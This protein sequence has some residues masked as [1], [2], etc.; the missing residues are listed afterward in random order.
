[1]KKILLLLLI[2]PLVPILQAKPKIVSL[3][4]AVTEIICFLDGES[5]LTGRSSACD[6]PAHI[7]KLPAV[8]DHTG[9]YLEKL[10]AMKPDYVIANNF[11]VK[12]KRLKKHVRTNF[13]EV[14]IK[15][16]EDYIK[17]LK[18]IGQILNCP[19]KGN[20]EAE[21][22]FL[23]LQELRKKAAQQTRKPTA[24]WII[25]HNPLMIAGPGSLPD[26]V[27]NLAGLKNAAANVKDEYFK[28]SRE[29]LALQKPDYIIWTVNGVPFR[30]KGF[31]AKYR[32]DQVISGLNHDILL[33]PGPRIFDGIN[34]L[35]D[36]L[37]K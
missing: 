9:F 8:G 37:K 31:W 7:K 4:P 34:Q 33:R 17:A 5:M 29:W 27:M 35:R 19:E 14:P 1:M 11:T 12:D 2:L 15:T 36:A 30:Q 23:K 3:T 24:I 13:I 25:W 32:K 21:K 20:K 28:C 22:A 18:T 6:Y 26:T 10:L 16:I